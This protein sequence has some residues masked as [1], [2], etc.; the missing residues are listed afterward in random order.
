MTLATVKTSSHGIS[1]EEIGQEGLVLERSCAIRRFEH[2]Y[3]MTT[4]GYHE[5][6][7]RTRYIIRENVGGIGIARLYLLT[8]LNNECKKRPHMKILQRSF[9]NLMIRHYLNRPLLSPI[10]NQQSFSLDSKAGITFL[11]AGGRHLPLGH[12]RVTSCLCPSLH[13]THR[14]CFRPTDLYSLVRR[15]RRF[16]QVHM[17]YSQDLDT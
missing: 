6:T 1:T 2:W 9:Q 7:R 11:S 16:W 15:T 13:A 4:R 10:L 14:S 17:V 12:E 8:A 5:P 3:Y